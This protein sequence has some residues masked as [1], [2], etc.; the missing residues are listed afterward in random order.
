[1]TFGRAQVKEANR[2]RAEG[3]S[4]IVGRAFLERANR[5]SE[6]LDAFHTRLMLHRRTPLIGDSVKTVG[7]QHAAGPALAVGSRNI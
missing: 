1:M 6:V 7:R 4:P 2:V 5:S 3:L